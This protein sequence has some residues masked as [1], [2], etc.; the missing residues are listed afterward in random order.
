MFKIQRKHPYKE[1]SGYIFLPSHML[2]GPSKSP[3]PAVITEWS[4]TLVQ[5]Q[6]AI[7]PL[8]TQ[9]QISLELYLLPVSPV[10]HTVV[11]VFKVTPVT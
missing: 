6:V 11:I 1:T 7:G 2:Q 8:Q 4:K 9:V 5:I 3:H 10:L